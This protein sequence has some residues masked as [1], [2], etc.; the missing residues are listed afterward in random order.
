MSQCHYLP[1]HS[2]KQVVDNKMWLGYDNKQGHMGPAKLQEKGMNST[3][4]VYCQSSLKEQEGT[5]G[6]LPRTRED[7]L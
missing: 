4:Q 2:L 3:Y 5:N 1:Y 7:L 6:K